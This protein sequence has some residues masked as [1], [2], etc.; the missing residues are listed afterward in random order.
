VTVVK[1]NTHSTHPEM[2]VMWHSPQ[3]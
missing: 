1:V 3:R 2:S